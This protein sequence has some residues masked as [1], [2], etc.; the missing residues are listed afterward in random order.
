ME[1]LEFAD[2]SFRSLVFPVTSCET[3]LC[4]IWVGRGPGLMLVRLTQ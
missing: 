3:W 4:L 1:L 2:A